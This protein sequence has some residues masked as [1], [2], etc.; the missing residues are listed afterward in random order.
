MDKGYRT[1]FG[2]KSEPFRSDLKP[3]EILQTDE[4][5][6][7]QGR[8]DYTIRLGACALVTG[9]IGSGKSTAM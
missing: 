7:V 2:F 4:L 1:F 5:K 6:A 3:K 8:F 9:E